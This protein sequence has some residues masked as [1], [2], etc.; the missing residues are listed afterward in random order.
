MIKL[1][2]VTDGLTFRIKE[3]PPFFSRPLIK[4]LTWSALFHLCLLSSFRIKMTDFH[5]VEYPIKP[6]DVAI[7]KE[8]SPP[9]TT[10]ID[11]KNSMAQPIVNLN[12]PYWD[13]ARDIVS[14][15]YQSFTATSHIPRPTSFGDTVSDIAITSIPESLSS[16]STLYPLRLKFSPAVKKLKLL[17]D[18]SS[19]FKQ[20]GNQ[21]ESQE[22]LHRL[23][24]SPLR[25]PIKYDVNIN[26]KNGKIVHW[27][28]EETLADKTLQECA[29]TL[30]TLIRFAPSSNEKIRGSICLTFC[31]TGQEM[32]QF[33]LHAKGLP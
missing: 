12:D 18:G 20:K 33:F 5:E 27:S 30:M 22:Q 13:E 2:P 28:R 1:E 8:E 11:N 21:K 31:C 7:E 6:I 29:D 4:A 23:L 26:G 3:R 17:V 15:Q 19:L 25:F 9:I 10:I 16:T 14:N 32:E 24:L